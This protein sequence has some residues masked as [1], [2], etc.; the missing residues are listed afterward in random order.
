L[1]L[2]YNDKVALLK[3]YPGQDPAILD[4]F[5]LKYKG[6]VI[7]AAGLG[8]VAASESQNSWL[9]KLKK[10]IRDGLVICATPQTIFGRLNPFVYS[11]G[12][13]L[14]SSGVIFLEDMLSE[15]A[16]V[17]L[18][19]VLGHH[20]WKTKAKDKMLENFAGELNEKLGTEFL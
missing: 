14:A 3:F 1:D 16:F 5:A 8:H 18:S 9:P 10:H 20:G 4:Y 17:K 13:E 12:R 7:E 15:T 11:T 6:L 2:D 19:W